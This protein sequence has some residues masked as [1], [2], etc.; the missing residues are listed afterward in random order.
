MF[1]RLA[2]QNPQRLNHSNMTLEN[3]L[4]THVSK[5]SR[6]QVRPSRIHGLGVFASQDI[7]CGTVVGVCTVTH[8]HTPGPHTLWCVSGPVDVLCELRYINHAT[9]PN[10]VFYETLEVVALR[11]IS[12]GE[13][14]THNYG[15]VD[16]S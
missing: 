3:I 11:D 4:A 5:Q 14:L 10:V 7:C 16:F 15:E 12:A 2:K 8:A 9:E 13:E 1:D 6:L